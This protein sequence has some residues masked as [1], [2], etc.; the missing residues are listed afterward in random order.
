MH[1]KKT[2]TEIIQDYENYLRFKSYMK[3]KMDREL[4]IYNARLEGKAERSLEIARHL[5]VLGDSTERIHTVTD[6]PV[7]IIKKM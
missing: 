1:I 2:L 6:V 5:K 7:K 3:Y 4:Y